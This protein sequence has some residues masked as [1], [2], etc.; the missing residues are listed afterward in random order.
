VLGQV[1]LADLLARLGEPARARSA[2]RT[3]AA[4]LGE[5]DPAEPVDGHDG[6][7][8]GRVRDLI[9][10]QLARLDGDPEDPDGP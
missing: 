9:A 7:A 3:A 1:A 6:P 5:G 4:L 10:A 8:A 2:L